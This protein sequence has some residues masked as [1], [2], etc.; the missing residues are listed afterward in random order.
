MGILGPL[1][2]LVLVTVLAVAFLLW[3]RARFAGMARE[4]AEAVAA[5]RSAARAAPDQPQLWIEL[6]CRLVEAGE[7]EEAL[8]CYRRVSDLAPENDALWAEALNHQGNVLDL[9]GESEQALGCYQE[10]LCLRP[11]Y[12]DL[13]YNL[14]TL[15]ARRGEREEARLHLQEYLESDPDSRWAEEARRI[16]DRL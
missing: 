10:A 1:F 14:G 11:D 9:I 13:H 16:L 3:R 8:Q 12:A 7:L 4:Q 6:A 15:H 2:Y 5:A